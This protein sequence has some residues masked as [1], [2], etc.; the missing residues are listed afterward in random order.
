MA[1][2]EKNR[3]NIAARKLNQ[4][5]KKRAHNLSLNIRKGKQNTDLT[6]FDPTLQQI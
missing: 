4:V 1:N 3:Y 2:K 5:D 6:M